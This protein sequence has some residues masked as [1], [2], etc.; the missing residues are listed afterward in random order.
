MNPTE[1]VNE[2]FAEFAAEQHA[3]SSN[4][5]VIEGQNEENYDAGENP[6]EPFVLPSIDFLDDFSLRDMRFKTSTYDSDSSV[7]SDLGRLMRFLFFL[8]FFIFLDLLMERL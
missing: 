8:C 5:M 7:L 1:L 4:E 6:E 2:V 3:S